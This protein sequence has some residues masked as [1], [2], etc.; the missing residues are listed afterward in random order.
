MGLQINGI[1]ISLCHDPRLYQ[2]H[3]ITFQDAMYAQEIIQRCD[4]IAAQAKAQVGEPIPQITDHAVRL[5]DPDL[6]EAVAKLL[7]E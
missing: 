7:K 6:N 2:D 5:V 4:R 3:E 1:N